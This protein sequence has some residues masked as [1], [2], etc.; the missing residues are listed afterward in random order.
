MAVVYPLDVPVRDFSETDVQM[1][2]I[3]SLQVATFTGVERVQKFEGD[4]WKVTIRWF[5]LNEELGRQITAFIAALRKSV[6]TFVVPFPGYGSPRGAA[7][8]NPSSP[9]VNGAS[10]AGKRELPVKNAPVSLE[11]WLLSGDIIQVGPAS[12]PHWHIVLTDVTTDA[13]GNATIDVWPALRRG[14]SD[15][16]IIILNEPLGICRLTDQPSIPIRPPVIYD[17]TSIECREA[18]QV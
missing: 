8:S 1:V 9:L 7:S 16:D 5:N 15:N 14:V 17:S 18:T 12:R 11:D 2:D 10:L 13:T 6:G 4:Y 3:N